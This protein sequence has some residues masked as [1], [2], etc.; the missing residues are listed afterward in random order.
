MAT[1]VIIPSTPADLQKVNKW[2]RDAVDCKTRIAAENSAIK[3]I[4]KVL[5]DEFKLPPKFSNK[6]IRTMYKGDFD[7]QEMEQEDF[8][9]LYA[10]VVK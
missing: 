1:T 3:D 6:L 2:V 10:K 8:A 7:K 4:V 5:K 9:E